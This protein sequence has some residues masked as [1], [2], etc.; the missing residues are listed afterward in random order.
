MRFEGWVGERGPLAEE[1]A[2]F[3]L[4]RNNPADPRY[5][6][7]L[8]RLA[9]PLCEGLPAGSS[10][11]DFAGLESAAADEMM[12][13]LAS[14][15]AETLRAVDPATETFEVLDYVDPVS[16]DRL[17]N[18]RL[19][20]SL[21]PD[22]RITCRLSGT[23][24]SDAALRIY[25]ERIEPPGGVL[26]AAPSDILAPLAVSAVRLIDLPRFTGRTAPTSVS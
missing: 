13:V 11:L 7:F 14:R 8:A 23:G 19:R 4:H 1:R 15:D 18:A 22:A 20:V 16:G 9:S 25:I 17:A 6:A 3:D 24:S 10:G 26:D 12:A 2:K 21:K 5:R